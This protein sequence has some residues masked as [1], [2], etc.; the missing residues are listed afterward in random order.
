M[1][2]WQKVKSGYIEKVFYDEDIELLKIKFKKGGIFA[3][4]G[5]P[6][7]TFDNLMVAPSIG[8]FFAHEIRNV[9]PWTREYEE[10]ES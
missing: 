3:Y 8:A 2:Q 10:S 6:K 4:Q 9:F 5:V 1:T 7:D